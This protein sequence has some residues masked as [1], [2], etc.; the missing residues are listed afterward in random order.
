MG[1]GTRGRRDMGLGVVGLWDMGRGT[2]GREDM[3]NKQPLNFEN[4]PGK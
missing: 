3:I 1:L 2:Q 4:F